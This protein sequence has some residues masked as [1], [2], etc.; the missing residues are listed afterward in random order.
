MAKTNDSKPNGYALSRAW[1][2]FAF[3]NQGMVSGNHGCMFLWFLEKNNRMGWAK[4]FGAPRDETMAAVGIT[5]FNTYRKIFSDLVEWGFI[6]VIKESKN[7]Y[8]AHIIALSKNDQPLIQALDSA[9]IQAQGKHEYQHSS[10]TDTDSVAIIKPINKETIKPQT[11]KPIS[12]KTTFS[13][14][15]H[16]DLCNYFYEKSNDSKWTDHDCNFQAQKFIDFYSSKNWM[17]GK[18]K[19]ANWKSAAS[20]WINRSLENI[21]KKSAEEKPQKGFQAAMDMYNKLKI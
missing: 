12:G 20:G 10:G 7:Q 15:T 18:N 2:D 16:I 6:N 21:S 5:S 13:P 19:M 4:Q 14:P 1:F 3:E 11:K 8:T 9:L 17:V